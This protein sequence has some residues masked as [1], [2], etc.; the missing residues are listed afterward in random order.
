[1]PRDGPI[2]AIDP[3]RTGI[4]AAADAAGGEVAHEPTP[5][6]S[7]PDEIISAVVDTP[8]GIAYLIAPPGASLR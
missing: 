5:Q 3:D 8:A 1:M 4:L 2:A 7:L 6:G